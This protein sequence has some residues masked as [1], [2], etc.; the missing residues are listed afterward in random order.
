M[1]AIT[2]QHGNG[3]RVKNANYLGPLAGCLAAYI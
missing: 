1:S 2:Y 3:T